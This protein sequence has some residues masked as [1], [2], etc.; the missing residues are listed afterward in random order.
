MTIMGDQQPP[1]DSNDAL[2]ATTAKQINS[3]TRTDFLMIVPFSNGYP[4]PH[5]LP[6]VRAASQHAFPIGAVAHA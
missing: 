2:I 5:S 6:N 1:S 3:P 4:R